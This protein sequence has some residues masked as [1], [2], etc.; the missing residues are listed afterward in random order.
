MA[1]KQQKFLKAFTKAD[2]A[3]MVAYADRC[4]KLL[5]KKGMKY[6]PVTEEGW[7]IM[8][9]PKGKKTELYACEYAPDNKVDKR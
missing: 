3:L 7:L 2:E 6:D 5:E 4:T 8:P 9:I 1:L